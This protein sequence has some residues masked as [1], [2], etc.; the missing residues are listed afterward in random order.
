MENLMSTLIDFERAA[1]SLVFCAIVKACWRRTLFSDSMLVSFS[2][3]LAK[4]N[5]IVNRWKLSYIV[6]N[7]IVIVG[8]TSVLLTVYLIFCSC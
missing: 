7:Y 5:Y 6:T 4:K 1:C 2:S 3:S 8:E